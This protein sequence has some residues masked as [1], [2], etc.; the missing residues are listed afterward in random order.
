MTIL[1]TGNP[2][3]PKKNKKNEG[4]FARIV[5]CQQKYAK[6]IIELK[7]VEATW[8]NQ[9]IFGQPEK[10]QQTRFFSIN[11]TTL[12]L[13]LVFSEVFCPYVTCFRSH[14]W[15]A[16]ML[17]NGRKIVLHHF[18]NG[19]SQGNKSCGNSILKPLKFNIPVT[20]SYPPTNH[21]STKN[22]QFNTCLWYLSQ[23]QQV[24]L[25]NQWQ[26]P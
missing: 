26:G 13:T 21:S 8:Q 5:F 14:P 3:P 10:K 17:G 19:V 20:I 2:P 16:R 11:S 18:C 23:F 9:I 15:R 7:Y 22:I 4:H 24:H 12:K 6:I 25:T 1:I